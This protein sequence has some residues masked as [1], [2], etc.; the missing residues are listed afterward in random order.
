MKTNY[1]HA[2]NGKSRTNYNNATFI[3]YR[4]NDKLSYQIIKRVNTDI[5]E[6]VNTNDVMEAHY[7]F[8]NHLK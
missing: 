3:T 2:V 6:I 8:F 7:I 1:T 4:I 5:V